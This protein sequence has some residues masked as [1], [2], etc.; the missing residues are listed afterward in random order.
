M[1]F[2]SLPFHFASLQVKL[3]PKTFHTLN[4]SCTHPSNCR[5]QI[6]VSGFLPPLSQFLHLFLLFFLTRPLPWKKCLSDLILIAAGLFIHLCWDSI[7]NL[8][9]SWRKLSKAVSANLRSISSFLI[10]ASSSFKDYFHLNICQ[11]LN[12]QT[13][14]NNV[15]VEPLMFY[16]I[17]AFLLLWLPVN[18]VARTFSC[19]HLTQRIF[20]NI[21]C[22]CTCRHLVPAIMD[23][24]DSCFPDTSSTSSSLS[25]SE[26]SSPYL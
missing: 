15:D 23:C 13:T 4:I 3:L 24:S 22:T 11:N 6:S 1:L 19:N 20:Y 21:Y 25:L 17:V 18:I 12:L 26:K 5:C 14:D 16:P 9:F 10:F 7:D 8:S 2:Y